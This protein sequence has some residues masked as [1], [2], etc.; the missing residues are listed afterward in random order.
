MENTLGANIRIYRKNKGFTQE[1]LS[2]LLNVT[3]QA[4]SKWESGSGLPDLSMLIPLAHVLGVS[5]DALL[6]YDSMSEN[7]AVVSHVRAIAKE[8]RDSDDGRAEKAL[9]VSEY[10]STETTLNPGCFELIK[11]YVEETANLSMY[12]DPVLENCFPDETD[13][14][15]KI[16]K[17]AIRKGCYLIGHCNDKTLIEKTH[18]AV[19][20]IYIHEKD[21][22][23]AREHI[24]V[25]P[26]ISSNRIKEK[27]SMELTFFESGFEKMKDDIGNNRIMLFELIASL[28]NTY[29][30]NYGWW[31]EKDE[32]IEVIEWCERVIKAYATGKE[33]IDMNHYLRIR[34]S[35]AFFKLV[36]AKRAGDDD[37]AVRLYN[38]FAEEIRMEDLTEEQKQVV[39]DLLQNDISHYGKY[40]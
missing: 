28:L 10:L 1:E 2:D 15:N 13:R 22:D 4:V 24:N 26:S 31:G 20:W 39:M 12:A 6:G 33:A 16:F 19:A 29:G 35:L 36:A 18:F 25:L 30:E 27:L 17:D 40:S 23:N 38:E 34:R 11:D 21:F 32:A 9:K 3:P 8:M 14:V 7:D 37:G 5:T